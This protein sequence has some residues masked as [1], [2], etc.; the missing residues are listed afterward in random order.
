VRALVISNMRSDAAHPGRG[1]FVRDQAAALAELPG[2][3]VELLEFPP[4]KSALAHATLAALGRRARTRGVGASTYD[5]VHAHFGLSAYPALPV[6]A[7]AHVLTLHGNDVFDPRSRALTRLAARR[8]DAV[9]AVS[10]RLAQAF[11]ESDVRVLPCGVNT[12]RFH[13][14]ER[15]QARLELGL[16]VEVP[17]LLFPHDPARAPKRHDRAAAL[18]RASRTK[19]LTAGDVPPE[20]MPLLINAANAVLVPSEVEG[21]GLAVLEALACDVPV[22]ATPVGGHAETLRD[23][24]GVLCAPFDLQAWSVAVAPLLAARDPRIEGRARAE[25]YSHRRMAEQV[26]DVWDS[27]AGSMEADQ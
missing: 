3:D 8:M 25:R 20:R 24:P 22:L 19:L 21:F 9:L 16:P 27:V 2:R 15:A 12:D 4:G 6:P 1:S 26:A 11:G 10:E 23:V 13:P 14:I 5:V 18:A 17:L 7:R